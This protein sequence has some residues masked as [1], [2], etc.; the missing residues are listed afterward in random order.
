M[1]MRAASC[2]G[3]G[4]GSEEEAGSCPGGAAEAASTATRLWLARASAHLSAAG[5]VELKTAASADALLANHTCHDCLVGAA[6][7]DGAAAGAAAAGAAAL[8]AA[9]GVAAAGAAE[10]AGTRLQTFER[11]LNWFLFPGDERT[12]GSAVA[13]AAGAG[14]RRGRFAL[15]ATSASSASRER[16]PCEL[17][18]ASSAMSPSPLA[19]ASAASTWAEAKPMAR[20]SPEVIGM[21]FSAQNCL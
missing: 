19:R 7:A 13:A 11:C 4:S 20:R 6:A 3:P 18:S 15:G 1:W 5:I 8:A 14:S 21:I 9:A 2:R 17:R 10:G 12:A 16:L